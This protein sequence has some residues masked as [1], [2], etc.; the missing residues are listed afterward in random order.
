[1]KFWKILSSL[2]EETLPG[3]Q[4]KFL[5]YK[6]LKK[7]LNLI[8]PKDDENRASKRPRLAVEEGTVEIGNEDVGEVTK[9]VNDFQKLLEVE[10]EKFNEFYDDKEEHYVILWPVL[11]DKVAKAKGSD[12]ELIKIRRELVNFHGEMVLLENYSQLNY[13]GLVKIIKKYDKRSG[14]LIRLPFIQEVLQQPFFTTDVLNNLVKEC[15]VILSNIFDKESLTGTSVSTEEEEESSFTTVTEN[16]EGLLK[17]IEH[18]E[19][20]YM[21]LILSA[22]RTLD[23]I[24]GGSSTVSEF[25]LPPLHKNAME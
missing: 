9:E 4:D 22:L 6:D 20:M 5:S 19:S 7:Q 18:M 8:Y 3:W 13:I 10:I 2:I 12:E 1:M 14:D 16:K 24:R 25:S 21:K 11:R 17:E 15:L 23:E